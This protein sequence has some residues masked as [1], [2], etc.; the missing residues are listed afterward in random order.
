MGF[1]QGGTVDDYMD[2]GLQTLGSLYYEPVW[3]FYRADLDLQRLTDLV[4]LRVNIGEE[5]SGVLP[6]AM[7]LLSVNNF[8]PDDIRASYDSAAQAAEALKKGTLD[9]AFFIISPESDLIEDMLSNPD[10]A[11][12]SFARARAYTRIF[13]Y[14]SQVTLEEGV[15]NLSE[16]IPGKNIQL[17]AVTAQLVVG[18]DFHP[19]LVRLLAQEAEHIHGRAGML[20]DYGVFPV[21]AYKELPAHESAVRYYDAGDTWLDTYLPP[22]LAGLLDRWGL[23]LLGMLTL[24]TI[25]RSI[26]P[27]YSLEVDLRVKRWYRLLRRIES[28][29]P[30]S[31]PEQIDMYIRRLSF[32]K[33]NVLDSNVPFIYMNRI[34]L[35]K[36]HINMVLDQLKERREDLNE[37]AD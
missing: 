16:N 4:G 9:A 35:L 29:I 6:V 7:Q 13:P 3:I 34:Y 14:M 28:D 26:L 33:R 1:V 17:L 21:M 12:F 18:N 5:G 15:I 11:I 8:T 2:A 30:V 31:S 19:L 37:Q 23:I 32:L 27:V 20:E 22:I 10:I 25:I 36:A 24:Y